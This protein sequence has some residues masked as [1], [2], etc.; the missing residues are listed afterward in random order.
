MHDYA[1]PQHGPTVLIGYKFKA[2]WFF[3]NL[4]ACIYCEFSSVVPGT[5]TQKARW[6]FAVKELPAR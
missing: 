2:A 6:G 5:V 3:K 4:G 1:K